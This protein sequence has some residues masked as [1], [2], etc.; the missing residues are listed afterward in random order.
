MDWVLAN[1]AFAKCYINVIIIFSLILG[2]HMCIIF[3]RFLIDLKN[4]TLNY[5]LA[6]VDFSIF[7]WSTWVMNYFGG[8]G[9]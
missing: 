4:T 6:N 5:I 1:L 3:R 2:D 9:I 7:K 8:L